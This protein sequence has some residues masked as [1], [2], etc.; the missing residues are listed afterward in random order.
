MRNTQRGITF[1]G[2]VILVVF[3]GTF[4][5]AGIRLTPVYLEY[6]EVVKALDGLKAEAS[7]AVSPQL[8]RN[9]IQKHFDID[10][11]K[12]LDARDV[13]ITRNGGVWTIHAGWTAE[14]PFVANISFL[15]HFD[16]VVTLAIG[17]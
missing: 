10:D 9:T 3:M 13:E 15:L 16:K 5:Y 6:F 1:I 8:I 12:S 11:V 7:S 14:T 2:L 4:V 17:A